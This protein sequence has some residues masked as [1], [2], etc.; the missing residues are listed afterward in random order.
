MIIFPRMRYLW[1][2]IFLLFASYNW[3]QGQNNIQVTD[4]DLGVSMANK[5]G[6]FEDANNTYPD[7][8]DILK[9][10]KSK[11]KEQNETI[12][13]FDFTSKSYW[14]Y[15]S[16]T[17][18]TSL[19]NFYVE[20]ARTVTNKVIFYEMG[21][22]NKVAHKFMSG[23]DFPYDVKEIAH[24]K[25]LFPIKLE[26]GET[27]RFYIRLSSDG[28]LLFAPLKVH[29]TA[30]FFEQDF[31]DQFKSGFYYG[32][33]ALTV[34]IYF[35]FFYFLQD[36]T[37]LFYILY[38]FSQGVLQFSL[39][40]YS[41]D[42]FFPSGGYFT[43]HVLL[44]FAGLTVIFLLI[45]VD[46]FL[47]LQERN[48]RLSRIFRYSMG[49]MIIIVF[50]SLIPGAPYEI[51]YPIINGASLFSILLAAY[52]IIHLRVQGFKVDFFFA[53][54]FIILIVG[55]V[56]F[57]LGNL[58]IVGDKEVSLGALK[59]SSALEF[60]VLSISM[61]SKYGKLQKDKLHAQREALRTLSEKNELMDKSNLMLEKQ[62]AERT[63]EI[64]RQKEELTI[65]NESIV[66]S[67][68]YAKRIQQAILP[69]QG[70]ID[71]LLP[72]SFVFYR[73]KDVVSGDFYFV[74]STKATS[75]DQDVYTI[76]A[77]VDCTGHGVPGA[78]MSIVGNNILSQTLGQQKINTPG[79]ALNFLNKGVTRTLRQSVID[80]A[81]V[82]DG[83]DIALCALSNDHKKLLFAGAKNPLYIIRDKA[84]FELAD[85]PDDAIVR[86]ENERCVLIEIKGD[87]FPIG[88]VSGTS[89]HD[90]LDHKLELMTGDHIY[91]FSDGYA[92][93]FGGER[94]KKFNYR[95]FRNVLM[96]CYGLSAHEQEAKL[97]E[98]FLAWL[99]KGDQI[100]DVLVIGV[101]I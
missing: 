49:M 37:F 50:L 22:G 68:K 41:H 96:N 3:G 70:Q 58:S 25:H 35:F 54:A 53:S 8:A 19:D 100:D 99:G 92:D 73:P 90:F 28:E 52:A 23:D 7:I 74:E 14:L 72:N 46:N 97:E 33:I 78:F 9:V 31:R 24:R 65:K 34:I 29:D 20:T 27:K 17:N 51:S 62:V 21:E 85:F 69:S 43:N 11:F 95:R 10:D 64:E 48:K 88:N 86:E 4:A 32:L 83:M 55:G 5:V 18:K 38:V 71:E 77:A 76:F 63:H 12:L 26:K 1:S 87:K 39:D 84:F 42:H 93:Q 61:S 36:K 101:N 98:A 6:V 67:I 66:S 91:V 56:V 16:L 82:R 45:Y 30:Q 81:K 80:G 47:L 13:N 79:Q 44:F 60:V 75:E 59:L 2:I 40:G 89:T 94:H 57:I 15:F